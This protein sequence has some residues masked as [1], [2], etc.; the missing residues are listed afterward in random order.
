MTLLA[1]GSVTRRS[2]Q[3]TFDRNNMTLI[4]NM[5]MVKYALVH[6]KTPGHNEYGVHI[7]PVMGTYKTRITGV[8]LQTKFNKAR[9][10]ERFKRPPYKWEND[11]SSLSSGTT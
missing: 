4:M 11:S 3:K 9:V 8:I 1:S 10:A 5:D 2:P 7:M 6:A